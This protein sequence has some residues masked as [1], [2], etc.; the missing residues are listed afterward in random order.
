MKK[1]TLF[2]TILLTLL[3]AGQGWAVTCYVS[4]DPDNPG[5]EMYKA[6]SWPTA[7]SH[8]ANNTTIA[9]AVSAHNSSGDVTEIDGGSLGN[10][11]TESVSTGGASTTIQ[12]STQAGHNGSVIIA[13]TSGEPL[14]ITKNSCTINNLI[15]NSA[16]TTG[17]YNLDL[18]AG[19]TNTTI[20]DVSMING[21]R[22]FGMN[23]GSCTMNRVYMAN[24]TDTSYGGGYLASGT[25]IA[26]NPIWDNNAAQFYPQGGTYTFNNPLF[27]GFKIGAIYQ[28]GASTAGTLNNPREAACSMNNNINNIFTA[29]GGGT[30]NIITG[31]I[32]PHPFLPESYFLAGVTESS[33]VYVSPMSKSPRRLGYISIN[34]DDSGNFALWKS[35]A[36]YANNKGVYICFACQ[37]PRSAPTNTY[38]T[39]MATYVARGNDIACHTEDHPG[40]VTVLTALSITGRSGSTPTVDTPMTQTDPNSANWTGSVVLKEGGVT[41]KTIPCTIATTQAIL[42]AAIQAQTG[43]S[44]IL[45]VNGVSSIPAVCLASTTGVSVASATNFNYDQSSYWHYEIA[46]AKKAFE[47]GIGNGYICDTFVCPGNKTSATLQTW[48][49]TAANF[50][51]VGTTPFLIARGDDSTYGSYTLSDDFQDAYTGSLGL[52]IFEVKEIDVSL[53]M[54]PNTSR[55]IAAMCEGLQWVGGYI[56]LMGH[57]A[58]SY[59]LSQWQTM[60]DTLLTYPK[61][62]ILTPSAAANTIRTSGLWT[63]VDGNGMRW[64]RTFANAQDY[65]LTAASPAAVRTGGTNVGLTTDFDKNTVPWMGGYSMGPYRSPSMGSP[66]SP[67]PIWGN[68]PGFRH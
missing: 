30:L 27:M 26:N 61:I 33:N 9:A 49:A 22:P 62:S 4:P 41:V 11:Y 66:L 20:N 17:N 40:D 8:D 16:G 47:T 53:Q 35:V 52:K 23:G 15:L 64:T 32:L 7:G 5:K 58:T 56:M 68:F 12:G 55:D 3:L 1:L 28:S 2:L 43:W 39:D 34:I 60:I 50:T 6:G 51:S 31:D 38:F 59:T 10:T 57:D 18:T 19:S 44:A 36:D 48:L 54:K 67:L 65:H 42:I 13:P 63:D 46:E 25:L 21:K 45:N 24:H 37:G 29:T 14:S